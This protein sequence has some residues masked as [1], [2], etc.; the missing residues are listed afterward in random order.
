[1]GL[2]LISLYAKPEVSDAFVRL[3]TL[4][5][6][7]RCQRVKDRTFSLAVIECRWN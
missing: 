2:F 1:M 6:E 5:R 7:W 4:Q 3:V